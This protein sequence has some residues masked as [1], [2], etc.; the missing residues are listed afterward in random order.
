MENELFMNAGA[1]SHPPVITSPSSSSAMLNWVSMETQSV[2]PSLGCNLFWEK[3][4]EQSIFHSALSSLV[5]SP[6]PSNSNFSGGVVGGENVMIRELI[7]K[8]GNIVDI[9]GTPASNG[10]VSGS[11]YATPMS[12]PTPGRMMVMK[13]TTPITEIS[14]D[15]GFAERAARFSCF[16]SRSFNG[17]TNSPFPMNNEQP[18]ATNEKMPRISSSPALKPLVSRVPTGESSGEFSRKR[19]AKSKQN[20]PSTV[21]PSKE[22]EE[23]E[24]SDPKR[25]KKSEENGDK[26]KSIDPYKD[27]IHV[28]ARRGQATDSHSLAERVRREKISERMKLLQDLVPG[29]NKVTGKALMLDE[30]I[31]YVQS[32]QRQ[33]EF[34]SMKL[35]SVN[36]RLDFNMDAILS[37]DIFPSSNNLMHHQQ[38]LQLDSSAETLLGDHHN[39]NL[40]LN[41]DISSNNIINPLETSETRSFI[42]HLPTFAHFTDSISQVFL[43]ISSI[44]FLNFYISISN[45]HI[46]FRFC[47]QYS[48]FSEDD[49]TSIIHMGFAQN[50][51]HELNHGK[52]I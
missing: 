21:S 34:L 40:Q 49:L 23:K 39:N 15:P 4:T 3:S 9:Y 26:T 47:F 25:C 20:S 44:T 42:S 14:G 31:N 16:G 10:N 13:T 43:K 2:D 37:K 32:L 8:R 18:V 45:D 17:R 48:T 22:I 5:S 1:S 12:S 35:S 27:Y 28:R 51:L 24:D 7:G 29:C 38:V 6:T 30:I 33:V 19:K 36:T 41:P 11:C 50:R 52:E 46:P